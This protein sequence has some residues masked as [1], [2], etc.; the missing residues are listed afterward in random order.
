MSQFSPTGDFP[1]NELT[2]RSN[3]RNLITT[4]KF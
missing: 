4:K 3:E 2:K 1:E